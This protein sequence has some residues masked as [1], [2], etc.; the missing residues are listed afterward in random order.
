ML[1][2]LKDTLKYRNTIKPEEGPGHHHLNA[3]VG[4]WRVD[5]KNS[6]T[7]STDSGAI[8]SGEETYEWFEG[9]YFLINHWDRQIGNSRFTG[10]GWIGYDG[11][12]GKYLSYSISNSGFLRIYEC[13]VDDGE[14][15]FN[16]ENE[17]ALIK[18]SADGNTMSVL[19]EH[20]LDQKK[21]NLLCQMTGHRLN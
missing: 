1:S 17:R 15:K 20:T 10:M 7:A 8:V 2:E 13:E 18:L 14:I 21:W 3:F 16:G 11:S 5:G 19:W 4:S 9:D 12:T 6:P